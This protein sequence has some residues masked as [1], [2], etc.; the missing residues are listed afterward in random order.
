MRAGS[1]GTPAGHCYPGDGRMKQADGPASLHLT[2]F[3]HLLFFP[4]TG[5]LGDRLITLIFSVA[6]TELD[7]SI[8]A[9]RT[10]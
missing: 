5:A 10:P 9:L 8:L 3:L 6:L 4:W 2:G 7:F 1:H